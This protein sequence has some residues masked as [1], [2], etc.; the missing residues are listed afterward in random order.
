[1]AVP[2]IGEQI[3]M[4]LE[5]SNVVRGYVLQNAAMWRGGMYFRMQQ[6]GAG[7]CTSECSNVV[8]GYVLQNAAMWCGGMYFIF[9]T[10]GD[11]IDFATSFK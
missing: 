11:A 6:C 10:T 9:T 7:V 1:M 3:Q 2:L 5:C 4:D 8:R